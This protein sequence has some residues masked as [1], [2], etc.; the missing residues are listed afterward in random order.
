MV[1]LWGMRSCCFTA[2]KWYCLDK[3]ALL[4]GRLEQLANLQNQPNRS[5][6][7]WRKNRGRQWLYRRSISL[8]CLPS[9]S[10]D[11]RR[12]FVSNEACWRTTRKNEQT[13]QKLEMPE[14]KLWCERNTNSNNG[15]TRCSFSI[16]YHC[17]TSGD[18]N[19]GWRAIW[20]L[21]SSRSPKRN[22]RN[23][24]SVNIMVSL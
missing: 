2:L 21:R 7:S 10:H 9:V 15:K 6:R 18:A 8:H 3:R 13:H 22:C 16:L 20:D 1:Q 12:V 17:K 4:S 24:R 23:C 19:G 14:G 11:N 5:A